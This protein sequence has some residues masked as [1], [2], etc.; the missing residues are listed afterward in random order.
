VMAAIAVASN[1]GG[2]PANVRIVTTKIVIAASPAKVWDAVRDVYA[3]DTRLVPGMVTKVGRI[4]DVRTVTFANGFVVHE[5]IVSVD[6]RARRITYSAFGGN[7]TYHLA[8]MKVVA[9]RHQRSKVIWQTRFLPAELEPFIKH[10][11]QAGAQ[12]MKAHLEM[13]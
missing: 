4:G 8:T 3:V 2:E 13:R 5:R 6:D 7:A 10:N 9:E 11:M 12:V 1:S